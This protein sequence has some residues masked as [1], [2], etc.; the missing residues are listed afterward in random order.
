MY[1]IVDIET[2][3][4]LASGNN[5]TEIAIIVHD[6]KDVIRQFQSLINPQKYIPSFITGLTG[7]SNAMV[8]TAPTFA[9]I[10]SDVYEILCD[11]IF[12]AHNVSFD[13]SFIDSQLKSAG[14][15]LSSKKLCTI[16]L[17]RKV[18]PG[19]ESYSLGKLCRS[20]N[21]EIEDRH[22][23]YGDAKATTILFEKLLK[24]GG[25]EHIEKMLNKTQAVKR[26]KI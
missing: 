13:Y 23:A 26:D 14:Y 6:G 17:S 19:L 9:E 12:V 2:T 11:T 8:A 21:I 24:A 22:R 16:R 1:S 20:L 25:T 18:F 15:I 4:G 7:I 5:I 10:A 3:G